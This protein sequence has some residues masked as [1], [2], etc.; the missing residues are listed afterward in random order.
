MASQDNIYDLIDLLDNEEN[1]DYVLITSR[2]SSNKENG[3]ADLH[4]KIKNEA[5]F[6]GIASAL[7]ELQ[8]IIINENQEDHVDDEYDEEN[9]DEE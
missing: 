2:V 3:I 9:E 5:S 7:E 1:L 4:F 8:K 6:V